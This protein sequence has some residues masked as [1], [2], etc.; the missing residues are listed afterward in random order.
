MSLRPCLDL[1]LDSPTSLAWVPTT[2]ALELCRTKDPAPEEPTIRAEEDTEAA[3]AEADP[4][5]TAGGTEA[6]AATDLLQTV[7]PA[8]TD[9]PLMVDLAATGT[10]T[11]A[12]TV[13]DL[14]LMVDLR[15]REVDLP[16]QEEDL[17]LVVDYSARGFRPSGLRSTCP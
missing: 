10:G 1:L 16:S 6:L 9:L 14:L 11:E 17:A 8:E 3:M 4:A 7:D 12:L 13:M 5:A 2:A 15:T